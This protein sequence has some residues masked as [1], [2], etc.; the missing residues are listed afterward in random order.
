MDDSSTLERFLDEID[1]ADEVMRQ[2]M[3]QGEV[4]SS[5]TRLQRSGSPPLEDLLY[6]YDQL[7]ELLEF[8]KVLL[9][10]QRDVWASPRTA[11]EDPRLLGLQLDRLRG[12]R[13]FWE[14]IRAGP[15]PLSG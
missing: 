4:A 7:I 5:S 2:D 12:R 10:E 11:R 15:G 9:A 6:L 8:K 1:A 13:R 3:A 14:G